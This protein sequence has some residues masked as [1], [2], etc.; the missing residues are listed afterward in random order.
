MTPT[1]SEHQLRADIIGQIAKLIIA[2]YP[3][4]EVRPFGSFATQSYLPFGDIDLVV[5][6]PSVSTAPNGVKKMLFEMA[7]LLKNRKLATDVVVIHRAKVPIVKV[8]RRILT[9]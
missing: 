6:C 4:A 1:A 2:R 8:R 5:L 3:D 7:A 9:A